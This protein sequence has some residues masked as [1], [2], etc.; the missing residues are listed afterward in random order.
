MRKL[1][2]LLPRSP[3]LTVYKCFIRPHLDYGDVLYDQLNLFSLTNKIESVQYNAALAITG[4]IRGTSKEKLY[5]E[6]GLESLKDRRW[7]RRLC[8]LYKIVNTK[9]PA[10]LYDL[11]PSFQRSSGNKGC[12]YEPFCRTVSFK[13]S[14]LPYAIK[15]WNKLDSEIRNGKTFASFRKMLLN[16]IRP[17][18][19]S[20]HKIYDP[21]GIKLLTRLRL[22]FSHLSKHKFRH[23]FAD[24]LNPL[25]SC[26]LE[27]EST[28][29][30]FLRCHNYTTLRRALMTDLKNINDAIMS[31]NESDLL[32]VMLY[33][34]KKFDNNMDMSILTATIKFVKDTGRLDQLFFKYY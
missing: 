4:A 3:L 18:G 21:L 11:I 24:S 2:L 29:H 14:F 5:Q 30:F 27:T 32:H 13:N 16:F 8:Y 31:L 1:N 34:S 22:G 19:N 12:I 9:Q 7:L 17:I 25:C 20:T 10:Y 33:G 28:L 6:L 23:N 26:S 15:E